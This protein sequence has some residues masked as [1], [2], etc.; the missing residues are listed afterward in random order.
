MKTKQ[1]IAYTY[2]LWVL[3]FLVIFVWLIIHGILN[4]FSLLNRTSMLLYILLVSSWILMQITTLFI[5]SS[6]TQAEQS[7]VS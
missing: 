4:T 7:P 5:K 3:S 2:P 1:F 6:Q